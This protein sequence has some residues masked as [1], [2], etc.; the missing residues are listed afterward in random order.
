MDIL[1]NAYDVVAQWNVNEI[2]AKAID[3]IVCI[4]D[5]LVCIF[6]REQRIYGN[7]LRASFCSLLQTVNAR[8]G[9]A[10]FPVVFAKLCS[11]K[12]RHPLVALKSLRVLHA[13]CAEPSFQSRLIYLFD[14]KEV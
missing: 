13:L 12:E 8:T 3:A 2:S 5:L 9:R 10:D 4:C 14:W 11:F 1:Q 7:N 6:D